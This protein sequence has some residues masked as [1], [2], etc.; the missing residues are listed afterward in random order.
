MNLFRSPGRSLAFLLLFLGQVQAI[1][2]V[3]T[4]TLLTI[5]PTRGLTSSM[6]VQN[7][8]TV[9][10]EFTAEVMRWT[11]QGG[12]DVLELTPEALVNPPRFVLAPGQTQTVRVGLRARGSLPQSTYRVVLTGTPGAAGA[13]PAVDAAAIHGTIATRYAF[14][15][16]LFVTA[17]GAVAHLRPHLEQTAVGLTLHWTNDGT[18]AASIKNSS[19][20]YGDKTV[21]IGGT[22]VLAGSTVIVPLA[23]PTYPQEGLSVSYV[24]QGQEKRERL[25]PPAR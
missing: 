12:K 21:A 14:S 2:L 17:P 11:Q 3:L 25:S 9:P 10:V 22:Y 23:L 8:D 1:N 4:P 15:L 19:L 6:S 7:R 5:N 13:G 18:A 16:P 24:D 20:L